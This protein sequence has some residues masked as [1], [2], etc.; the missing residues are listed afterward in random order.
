MK[1]LGWITV[2]G[3]LLTTVTSSWA[4]TN[5]YDLLLSCEAALRAEA[6][7]QAISEEYRRLHALSPDLLKAMRLKVEA[8]FC[9]G[10]IEGVLNREKDQSWEISGI[11]HVPFCAPDGLDERQ[12]VRIVVRYLDA[13]LEVLHLRPHFLVTLALSQ[14]FPCPKAPSATPPGKRGK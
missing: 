5:G 3:A 12:V 2:W 4:E 8:G 6:A 10:V 9:Q 14:V 1:R 11:I 13:H 7:W